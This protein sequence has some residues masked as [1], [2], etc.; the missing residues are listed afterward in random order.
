[1]I[2]WMTWGGM[3]LAAGVAWAGDWTQWRGS[4]GDGIASN[5][6]ALIEG[7]GTNGPNRLW[8]SEQIPAG[9]DGGFSSV[10]IA[11]GRE[12]VFVN[13][14]TQ[15]PIATRKLT[16]GHLQQ[17][18]WIPNKL[19][20][21][22]IKAMEEARVS[23]ERAKLNGQEIKKWIDKWV[24]DHVAEDQ[25]KA[26]A[27][28]VA[29]RITRGKAALPLE[30]LSK[31]AEIRNKEFA[32]EAEFGQWLAAS[33]LDTQTVAA[34]RALVPTS[35]PVA[36]DV[37]VC[38]DADGKTVWKKEYPGRPSGWGSSSTPCVTG[39]RCYVAGGKTLYCLDAAT[40]NEI[41]SKGLA[42]GDISSSP[43][44]VD[45]VVAIL[46]GMLYGINGADG[47]PL[48]SQKEI[49]GNNPS[50]AVWHKGDA[51]YVLCNADKG[52]ACV[53]PKTGKILW[54]APG[55][56]SGTVTVEGDVMVL[57]GKTKE[58][59]LVA[60]R[61]ST[62]KAERIWS[63]DIT[64]RGTTPLIRDGCVYVV[65]A[66]RVGCWALAD[67]ALKWEKKQGGEIAS[68][69]LAD[70]KIVALVG[71]VLHLIRAAPDAYALLG[72]ASPG[73]A[74]CSSPSIADGRLYLRLTNAV[75]CFDLKKP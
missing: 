36:K 65:G 62:E 4:Q 34:V 42:G 22:L 20:E 44:L 64:D 16:D 50:P 74:T 70:G 61:L 30:T 41:W 56:G 28:I 25:K 43:V 23:D 7:W 46:G 19:P 75:A 47:N 71:G 21:D 10:T 37:I 11:G 60:Y 58:V 59:G 8:V 13:W 33:G 51:S 18:G 31:V 29:S 57:L 35:K 52:V 68:P 45:G 54:T 15:E 49:S 39:G 27:P 67:G 32:G 73:A 38:L 40:G 69:I 5:S 72:K 66:G 1:M 24:A 26:V 55:G 48:W 17:L 63:Q 2:R 12:Y 9:E 14:K 6:P 3:M 53:E